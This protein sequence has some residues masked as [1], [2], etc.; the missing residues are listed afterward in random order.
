MEICRKGST[1]FAPV[2]ECRRLDY[3][4]AELGWDCLRGSSETMGTSETRVGLL[5]CP[6]IEGPV[7]SSPG[8]ALEVGCPLGWM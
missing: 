3:R 2:R 4:E 8:P 5:S 6:G 7:D 1:R